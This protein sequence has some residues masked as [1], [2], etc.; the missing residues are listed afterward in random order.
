M[1]YLPGVDFNILRA[2]DANLEND[3]IYSDSDDDDDEEDEDLFSH[4]A[5]QMPLA[6]HP[7]IKQLTDEVLFVH[8]LFISVLCGVSFLMNA[9]LLTFYCLAYIFSGG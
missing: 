7:R 9:Q 5:A 6:P 1:S 2:L 3:L 8:P 4:N